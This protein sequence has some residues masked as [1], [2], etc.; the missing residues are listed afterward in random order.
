MTAERL[1]SYAHTVASV[2]C[3]DNIHGTLCR[4]IRAAIESAVQEAVVACG[5]KAEALRNQAANVASQAQAKGDQNV[6]QQ[7]GAAA[8]MAEL[9]RRRILLPAGGCETCMNSR[10]VPSTLAPG[11]MTRCPACAGQAQEGAVA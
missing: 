7:S 6:L 11:H 2:N 5:Q 4:D 10:Q 1:V 3:R 9:I 8:N